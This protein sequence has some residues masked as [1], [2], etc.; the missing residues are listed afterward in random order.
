MNQ[1]LQFHRVFDNSNLKSNKKAKT[2]Q[3]LR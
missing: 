3:M 2:I 1:D